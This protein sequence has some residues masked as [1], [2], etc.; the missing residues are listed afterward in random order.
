VFKIAFDA[1]AKL[2]SQAH[3]FGVSP[4]AESIK[5]ERISTQ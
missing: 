2:F 4:G 3:R 1:R 5:N